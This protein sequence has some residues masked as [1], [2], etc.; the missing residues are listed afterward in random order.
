[1]KSKEHQRHFKPPHHSQSRKLGQLNSHNYAEITVIN[2]KGVVFIKM[3]LLFKIIFVFLFIWV[4]C[5]CLQTHQ[6]RASDPITDGCELPCGCWELNSG[7]PEEQSV[8][9]TTGPSLQPLKCYFLKCNMSF[10]G[11]LGIQTLTSYLLSRLPNPLNV[12]TSVSK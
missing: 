7:P 4:H 6:K 9:L 3:L 11:V 12:I 1:M 2:T 10:T 5:S 8:L